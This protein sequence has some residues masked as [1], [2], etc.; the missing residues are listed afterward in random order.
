MPFIFR[1]NFQKKNVTVFLLHNP[2]K[3]EFR[4]ILKV[5][6][7]RYNLIS[8]DQFLNAVRKKNSDELPSYSAILTFDDGHADNFQLLSVFKENNIP[9]VVFICSGIVNTMR[10]FWFLHVHPILNRKELKKVSN[11]ERLAILTNHGFTQELDFEK[12]EALRLA[13]INEMKNQISFQSHTIF[14]PVLP[15]CSDE[16]AWHEI[17]ESKN[18]LERLL[19]STIKAFAYPNGDYTK[20]D[21]KL[22]REAGYECAFTVDPGY[23]SISSDLFKLKR[24]SLN[25]SSDKYE[26]IVKSS[27]L[28]AIMKKLVS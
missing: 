25:D 26:I 7:N 21:V 20:R 8:L 9:A 15:K 16:E 12:R 4:K 3:E 1:L 27:G 22:V 23:N 10:G 17:Y 13:E 19:S 2:S 24:L 11:K 5:L 18:S 28:W 6:E 14:H